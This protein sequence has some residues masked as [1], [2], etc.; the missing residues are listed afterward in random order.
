MGALVFLHIPKTG[1]LSLRETLLARTRPRPTFRI[2]HP[3][4]DHAKLAA[5]PEAGRAALGLVEGHMYYG[6]HEILPGPCRYVTL[7]REPA[8]RL[9]SWYRYVRREKW[10]PFHGI[11]TGGSKSGGGLTLGDCVERG[12]TTELDNYMTRSL[13]SLAHAH[14]PFGGVTRE[15][16][17]MACRNLERVEFVGTTERLDEFHAMLCLSM[18]WDA[19]AVK[20]LNRT[21][22]PGSDADAEDD[23]VTRTIRE[24]NAFDLALWERAGAIL[25]RR[26]AAGS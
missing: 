26:L 8:A 5:M 12:L 20:H 7:L 3:I 1:G 23:G 16:F 11:V 14:V 13:T 24:V 9:R 19:G 22:A 17:E 18:G 10:H 2:L 25:E 21:A 4:D 15:M 6:V